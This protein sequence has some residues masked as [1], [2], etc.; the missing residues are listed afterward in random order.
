MPVGLE[1]TARRSLAP[2]PVSLAAQPIPKLHAAATA[3]NE[4]RVMTQL[5][6]WGT[7]YPG[8]SGPQHL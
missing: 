6:V 5:L 7:P 4:L 2:S 3:Q 8:V 1:R